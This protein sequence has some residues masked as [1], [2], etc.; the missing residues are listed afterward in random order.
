MGTLI[1]LPSRRAALL[2]VRQVVGRSR[3][4]DL[5]IPNRRV[6]AEHAIIAWSG[7][8]WM[9]RDLGSTNGTFV[10]GK[11]LAVGERIRLRRNSL[12]AFGD[13]ED[14]WRLV[15]DSPPLPS[16][17]NLS[18]GSRLEQEGPIIGIPSGAD[19]EVTVYWSKTGWMVERD[20]SGEPLLDTSR[21]TVDGIEYEIQFPEELAGTLAGAE[22][23]DDTGEPLSGFRF[24]FRNHGSAGIGMDAEGRSGRLLLRPRAHHATML[25]LAKQRL[26]DIQAGVSVEDAGWLSYDETAAALGVDPKT[27]NVHIYRAR[28]ELARHGICGASAVV[29]RR[30]HTKE[31]RFGGAAVTI[32]DV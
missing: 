22:E 11:A 28:Q 29:E 20:G 1:H 16:I 26:H 14:A 30:S 8:G 17:V 3:K 27:L 24:I 5:R 19:P 4:T 7:V 6:S 10:D 31:V 13:A 18:D 25:H 2:S 32:L 15:S 9:V 21:V 12:L 23:E